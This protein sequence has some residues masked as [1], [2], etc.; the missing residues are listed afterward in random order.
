MRGSPRN[1]NPDN[2]AMKTITVDEL[3]AGLDDVALWIDTSRSSRSPRRGSCS[4]SCRRGPKVLA[5]EVQFA[6]LAAVAYALFRL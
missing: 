2:F 3:C 1:G 4:I 5:L 6:L